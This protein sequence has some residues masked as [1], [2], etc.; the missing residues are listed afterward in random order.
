MENALPWIA[1]LP[2]GFPGHALQIVADVEFGSHRAGPEWLA[3]L[4]PHAGLQ[5][6]VLESLFPEVRTLAYL[7]AAGG[8]PCRADW[9]TARVVVFRLNHLSLG[10]SEL[11][12]MDSI[13]QKLAWLAAFLD[14][15]LSQLRS[16]ALR[17]AA[18]GVVCHA[19][20]E[21]HLREQQT[22]V[23][24]SLALRGLL[25][26]WLHTLNMAWQKRLG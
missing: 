15:E 14:L 26:P 4:P 20:G 11:G 21:L 3:M 1:H 18:T 5:P 24:R 10:L 9:L 7:L 2:G 12:L 23:A 22:V 6:Q 8:S 13:N 19:A 16:F 17:G 25:A